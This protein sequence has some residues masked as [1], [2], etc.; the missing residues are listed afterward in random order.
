ME[1]VDIVE[2]YFFLGIL[3]SKF[4]INIFFFE[5]NIFNYYN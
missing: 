5:K 2:L 4:M 1:D 3:I